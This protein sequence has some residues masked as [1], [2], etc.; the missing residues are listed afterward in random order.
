[1]RRSH[2]PSMWPRSTPKKESHTFL[3]FCD[4][5]VMARLCCR[6]CV[7]YSM[8]KQMWQQQKQ[9]LRQICE[10]EHSKKK[11]TKCKLSHDPLMNIGID[12]QIND[13]QKIKLYNCSEIANKG[14]MAFFF[15]LQN[16]SDESAER[17]KGV[18]LVLLFKNV[19]MQRVKIRLC[20]L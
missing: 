2:V 10:R 14:S 7:V 16:W 20:P 18:S 19:S 1:M 9:F 12:A 8:Q 5:I 3:L 17:S 4:I 15:F 6:Q 13:W 11:S